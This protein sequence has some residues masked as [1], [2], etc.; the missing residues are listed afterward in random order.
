MD[1]S[2][3][4]VEFN[5]QDYIDRRKER[6]ELIRKIEEFLWEKKEQENKIKCS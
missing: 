6:E 2:N 5:E 1:D 4:P 3:K